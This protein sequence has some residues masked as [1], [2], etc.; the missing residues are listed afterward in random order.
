VA[1][2]QLLD[3]AELGPADDY[4]LRL[5]AINLI[6][7]LAPAN[8]PISNPAAWKAIIDTGGGSLVTGAQRLAEDVSRPPRLP[9]RSAPGQFKLGEEV[10]ATPGA[11]VL[12][13]PVMELIQYDPLTPEVKEK[14]TEKL[15]SD[16]RERFER[17]I[18]EVVCADGT[19]LLVRGKT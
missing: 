18:D 12:R 7:A 1:V 5:I 16:P 2:D 17:E 4:R 3:T 11:V 15:W 10:A 6:E 19:E 14:S 13:T 9:V 8:W